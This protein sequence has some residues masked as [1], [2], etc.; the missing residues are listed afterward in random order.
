[1]TYGSNKA[2]RPADHHPW[3]TGKPPLQPRP[4]SPYP[5]AK[6]TPPVV[7]PLVPRNW[8]TAQR[9]M[10]ELDV[11]RTTINRLCRDGVLVGKIVPLQG[12]KHG[13]G[14]RMVDPESVKA[15]KRARIARAWEIEENVPNRSHANNHGW[16]IKEYKKKLRGEA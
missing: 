10:I 15:Y 11:S 1:M 6:P 8:W 4:I 14:K 2:H 12:G 3:R 13:K 5:I 16:S 7:E 9:A